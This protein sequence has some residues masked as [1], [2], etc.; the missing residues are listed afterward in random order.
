MPFT[1]ARLPALVLGLVLLGSSLTATPSF[2]QE[3]TAG[4][5]AIAREL[6]SLTGTLSTIDR[7]IPSFAAQVRQQA[8]TRPDLAKDL[9]EVLKSF[10]P[11]LEQRRQ[12]IV[13]A[14]SRVYA[15]HMT[16]AEMKDIVAFFKTPSGSKYLKIQPQ[17]VDDVVAN[18]Q[19]WGD[20]VSEYVITRART[21][22]AK[23]GY[24]MQ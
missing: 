17:L 11:E 6:M 3:P 20:Q 1:F 14:A 10:Q 23:R 24:Q 22:M 21:E 5:L 16:E 8:I 7:L 15:K 19:A 18:I 13:N 2:A 4:Q 9:D 12:Q